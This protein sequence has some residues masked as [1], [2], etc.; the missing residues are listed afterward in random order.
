MKK[1]III[2]GIIFLIIISV[3]AI[4]IFMK[5]GS[6]K[7]VE[8]YGKY[9]EEDLDI[10]IPGVFN[11][12]I[13]LSDD[14]IEI[15]G[16]GASIDGNT[17]K[18]DSS[19]I[20]NIY[21]S[22]SQGQI[23]IDVSKDL[24]V[25]L[26][27]NGASISN[28]SVAPIYIKSS[29]KTIITL[30]DDTK[31]IIKDER[32]ESEGDENGAIFSKDDL[33][34]NGNGSLEVYTSYE[35][36]IVCKDNLKIIGANI[37]VVAEDDGIRG[38]DSF[39]VKDAS[40]NVIA[41]S[42]GIKSNKEDDTEEVGNI[43]IQDSTINITAGGGSK[44]SNISSSKIPFDKN[45]T[46]NIDES[47]KGIK[48]SNLIAIV[49]G[50]IQIDSYD[51]SIHSNKDIYIY[52]GD[53]L[54]SSNDDAVHA[55]ETLTINGGSIN[56]KK[57]YEGL[58]A[59][60]ININSGTIHII[61]EDDGINICSENDM[62]FINPK[63]N[64]SKNSKN[65]FLINGGY[66]VVDASGDG[67]DSNGSIYMSGGVVIVN[68]PTS[69]KDS[70][71]DYDGTFEITGGILVAVGSQGMFQT[72]SNSSTQCSITYYFNSDQ[73]AGNII[74]VE[75]NSGNNIITFSPSKAYRAILI[76]TPEIRLN[77]SYKIYFG[78]SI[79]ELNS[80]G[81]YFGDDYEKGSKYTSLTISSVNTIIGNKSNSMH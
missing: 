43:F 2:L 3:F 67:L 23:I 16:S 51:D 18:I 17:V 4:L 9:D 26:V 52:D 45:A 25:R 50:T 34:I 61:S 1:I 66:I 33:T 8:I 31:N 65:R 48:A 41:N 78:G 73:K 49:S 75:D 13:K 77:N 58:E 28:S 15:S 47:K 63:N 46:S 69:D 81:I 7:D 57:S 29:K 68:G 24:E 60:N 64:N 71:L 54:L 30:A 40:I 39:C 55:D 6:N 56:I 62:S 80:D 37:S 11:S 76:S 21:G 32:N 19:G 74:N 14:G 35:D 20:Y 27:L 12:S 38:N 22:I 59:K 42:D 79:K 36:G 5:N 44:S 70:P 53:I 72:T 10:T